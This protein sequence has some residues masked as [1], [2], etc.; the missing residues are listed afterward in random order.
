M[1]Y[2]NEC[3]EIEHLRAELKRMEVEGDIIKS[4]DHNEFT[5]Q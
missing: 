3:Q 2:S 4:R 1:F 5:N